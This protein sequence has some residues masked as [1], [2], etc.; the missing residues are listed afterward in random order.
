MSI[1]NGRTSG[2][3]FAQQVKHSKFWD[4]IKGAVESPEDIRTRTREL[5]GV[6]KYAHNREL[7]STVSLLVV[8]FGGSL[9]VNSPS[10]LGE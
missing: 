9:R 3:S 7:R 4:V 5:C 10:T 6:D 1:F 2:S 8:L